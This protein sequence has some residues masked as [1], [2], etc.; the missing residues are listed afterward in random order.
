MAPRLRK[1]L[2]NRLIDLLMNYGN[3]EKRVRKIRLQQDE[4]LRTL[5]AENGLQCHEVRV[6]QSTSP[7]SGSLFGSNAMEMTMIMTVREKGKNVNDVP[8]VKY[9]EMPHSWSMQL[10]IMDGKNIGYQTDMERRHSPILLLASLVIVRHLRGKK[11]KPMKSFSLVCPRQNF[12]T[13]NFS[14]CVKNATL[15]FAIASFSLVALLAVSLTSPELLL[16]RVTFSASSHAWKQ[17]LNALKLAKHATSTIA[18]Q[19]VLHYYH[20]QA[21]REV[22]SS[23]FDKA[24]EIF[25][26]FSWSTILFQSSLWGLLISIIPMSA[27]TAWKLLNPANRIMSMSGKTKTWRSHDVCNIVET[28]AVVSAFGI[29]FAYR[30]SSI[31]GGRPND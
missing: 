2:A 29:V 18:A 11:T 5:E 6:C 12:R 7:Q 28:F 3:L 21:T 19:D 24:L 31:P 26:K 15:F 8:H 10:A 16:S 20:P 22:M 14:L 23:I 13:P 9:L 30:S 4:E 1:F 25:K 27:S 17:V